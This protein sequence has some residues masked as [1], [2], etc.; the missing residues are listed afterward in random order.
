M[1]LDE[2]LDNDLDHALNILL[3]L[4]QMC[5]QFL[6]DVLDFNRFTHLNRDVVDHFQFAADGDVGASRICNRAMMWPYFL[7]SLSNC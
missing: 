7:S 6:T 5:L 4:N 1:F 2:L 3:D